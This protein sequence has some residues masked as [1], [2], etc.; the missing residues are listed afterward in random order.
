[1]YRVRVFDAA[2]AREYIY[3]AQDCAAAMAFFLRDYARRRNIDRGVVQ[4][5]VFPVSAVKAD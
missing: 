3:E 5:I 1:M 4:D 2:G